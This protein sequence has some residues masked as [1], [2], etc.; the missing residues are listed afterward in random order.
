MLTF[1]TRSGQW[2]STRQVRMPKRS[3]LGRALRDEELAINMQVGGALD[4]IARAIE[5]RGER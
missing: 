5:G 3:Y 1:R 2:V 4:R